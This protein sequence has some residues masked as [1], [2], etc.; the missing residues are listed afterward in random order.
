MKTTSALSL[1]GV[2]TLAR[3]QWWDGAP[4]CAVRLSPLTLHR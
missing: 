3:A 1:L 4:D 2:A